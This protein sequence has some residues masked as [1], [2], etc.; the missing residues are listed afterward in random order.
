MCDAC[1]RYPERGCLSARQDTAQ[2]LR[3]MQRCWQE[4]YARA[5]KHQ[6]K[7]QI[8]DDP[9]SVDIVRLATFTVARTDAQLGSSLPQ[10]PG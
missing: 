1:A 8:L 2:W 4:Y 10:S 6:K 3:D 9:R 5:R 7:A